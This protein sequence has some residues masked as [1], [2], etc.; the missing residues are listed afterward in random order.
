MK[1]VNGE[2]KKHKTIFRTMT[3]PYF[4]ERRSIL[5]IKKNCW[6]CRYA[7]FDLSKA[8]TPEQGECKFPVRQTN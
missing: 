6:F 2:G 4:K 5:E 3:C 1:K 7:S 8:E